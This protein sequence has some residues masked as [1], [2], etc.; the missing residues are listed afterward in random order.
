[1]ESFAHF[2]DLPGGLNALRQL[3]VGSKLVVDV[4]NPRVN[5][6]DQVI[7]TVDLFGPQRRELESRFPA[8]VIVSAEIRVRLTNGFGLSLKSGER[9]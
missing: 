4:K 1:L 5:D 9:A 3:T 8:G 7:V 6:K 2:H